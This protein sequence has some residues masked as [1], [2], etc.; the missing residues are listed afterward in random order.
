MLESTSTTLKQLKRFVTSSIAAS[1]SKTWYY[2]PRISKDNLRDPMRDGFGFGDKSQ[3]PFIE[4]RDVMNPKGFKDEIELEDFIKKGVDSKFKTSFNVSVSRP[5]KR[6][7]YQQQ[8]EEVYG[9]HGVDKQLQ[10]Q[11]DN[12]VEAFIEGYDLPYDLKLKEL[13]FIKASR[14]TREIAR[15]L[16]FPMRRELEKIFPKIK[17]FNV[18]CFKAKRST[19]RRA[20]VFPQ[21][22]Q[23]HQFMQVM[24]ETIREYNLKHIKDLNSR[25][26]ICFKGKYVLQID[27]YI[28]RNFRDKIQTTIKE[29]NLQYFVK[30]MIRRR[31]VT[32]TGSHEKIDS[33]QKCVKDIMSFLSPKNYPIKD[34]LAKCDSFA[35]KSKVGETFLDKYNNK[36]NGKAFARYDS[37]ANRLYIRGELT[38]REDFYKKLMTW[39]ASFNRSI[40]TE[41]YELVNPR[42]FFK[43]KKEAFDFARKYDSTLRYTQ[44]DRCLEIVYHEFYDEDQ[45]RMR[46]ASDIQKQKRVEIKALRNALDNLFEKNEDRPQDTSTGSIEM[47]EDSSFEFTIQPFAR[48]AAVPWSRSTDC[49]ADTLS[50]KFA[51]SSRSSKRPSR[52]LRSAR[53]QDARTKRFTLQT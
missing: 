35:L 19:T 36:N 49:I 28:Y 39:A 17:Q 20:Q 4:L 46:K 12:S 23:Y 48:S 47:R 37:K 27:D 21:D 53:G 50:A 24:T 25:V 45:D 9:T 44:Q 2:H 7:Y 15:Q 31:E 22:Y 33:M 26:R 38:R 3:S 13:D 1:T 34:E 32:I 42:R 29:A 51:S 40:K 14:M 11:I 16:D 8:R 10:M 43:N 41:K 18:L 5:Y 52:V 6:N 30:E